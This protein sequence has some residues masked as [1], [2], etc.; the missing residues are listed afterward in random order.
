MIRVFAGYDPREAAGFHV[1]CQ[2]LI[3]NSSAPISITPVMGKQRDGTNAFT[4]SR[5]M[6]PFEC[7][8]KGWAIFMDASDMLVRGDIAQLLPSPQL[9][10]AVHVVKHDYKT[11]HP[12]KYLGTDMEAPNYDYPRK[13]WSSVI[14]WDCGHYA[15]Q[16]LTPQRDAHLWEWVLI[17]PIYFLR[18]FVQTTIIFEI[19]DVR[20]LM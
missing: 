1:F 16:V 6:T 5:F 2:T 18:T 14:L 10:C 7:E 9:G 11:L 13:N 8:F 15:N 19:V 3:E 12:V 4:Y 20:P 17:M